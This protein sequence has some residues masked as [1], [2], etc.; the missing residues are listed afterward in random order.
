MSEQW[1]LLTVRG[2]AATDERAE[3]FVGTFVIHRLGSAEPVESVQVRVKRSILSEM[4]ATLGRLLT[5]SVGF[6]R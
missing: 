2:L 5:R 3:E 4:H 1:E 6:K